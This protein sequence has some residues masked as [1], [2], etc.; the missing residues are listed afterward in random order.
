VSA[1]DG[2][3]RD[4]GG[5]TPRPIADIAA[6]MMDQYAKSADQT[7]EALVKAEEDS[8]AR[9]QRLWLAAA[10]SVARLRAVR[11]ILENPDADSLALV[12]VRNWIESPCSPHLLLRGTTGTGKTV[13]AAWLVR[14]CT[15]PNARVP[16][17][18]WLYPDDVASAVLQNW[19]DRAPQLARYV[20][21]DELGTETRP[22]FMTALSR[23]LDRDG[24]NVLL[25]TNLGEEAFQERY[26]KDE[27]LMSRAGGAVEIVSVPGRDQRKPASR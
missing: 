10:L 12:A 23:L 18:T 17:V 14:H 7:P 3:G 20:V 16:G 8:A 2:S 25:T 26:G 24:C 13:A 5:S 1:R 6:N 27:R 19:S 9:K 21:V 15:E 11:F 22:D 4:R